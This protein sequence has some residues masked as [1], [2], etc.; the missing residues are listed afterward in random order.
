M[1]AKSAI[2]N[3]YA[4]QPALISRIVYTGVG[5]FRFCQLLVPFH[6]FIL[7]QLYTRSTVSI[8]IYMD[9]DTR[10]NNRMTSLSVYTEVGSNRFRQLIAPLFSG[11]LVR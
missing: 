7:V 10:Q 5:S 9:C 6:L 3:N 1:L 2:A 8:L 4:R 11:L